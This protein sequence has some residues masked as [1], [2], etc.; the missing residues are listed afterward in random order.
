MANRPAE[1]LYS[2]P[3]P[4]LT[5]VWQVNARVPEDSAVA[6]QVPIFFQAGDLVSNGVTAWVQ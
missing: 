4:G 2:G 5:G 6:R 3:A 1:V